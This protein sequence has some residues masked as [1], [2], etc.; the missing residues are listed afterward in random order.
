MNEYVFSSG[1]ETLRTS[2]S[3]GDMNLG[4]VGHEWGS[5]EPAL[6]EAKVCVLVTCVCELT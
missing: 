3:N 2:T 5:R 6:Y 1:D 4:T